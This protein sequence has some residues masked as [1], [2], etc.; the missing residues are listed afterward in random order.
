MAMHRLMAHL[1]IMKTRVA[2]FDTA[3]VNRAF[4]REACLH[5]LNQAN[6]TSGSQ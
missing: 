4:E 3:V 5:Q 6:I 2:E 1:I